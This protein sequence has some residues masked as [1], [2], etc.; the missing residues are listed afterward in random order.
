MINGYTA[1]LMKIEKV[2]PEL[3]LK[4][5]EFPDAIV[6][7]WMNEISTDRDMITMKCPEKVKNYFDMKI[8]ISHII[9][10]TRI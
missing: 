4:I 9:L 6:I 8:K 2:Y 5:I 10:N 1:F 3:Y 7:G